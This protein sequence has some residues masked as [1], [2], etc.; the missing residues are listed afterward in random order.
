MAA[1]MGQNG[2]EEEGEGKLLKLTY[3][4]YFNLK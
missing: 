1:P 3:K 2:G 4:V